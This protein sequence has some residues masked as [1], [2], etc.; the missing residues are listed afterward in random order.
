M[1]ASFSL[2]GPPEL[3]EEL[4]SLTDL[5]DTRV[6]RVQ[7]ASTLIDAVDAPIGP[8]TI[9]AVVS[10]ITIICG[11]TRAIAELIDKILDLIAKHRS[12]PKPAWKGPIG[13]EEVVIIDPISGKELARISLKADKGEL[14]QRLAHLRP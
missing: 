9:T 6:G 1:S 10:A 2:V 4:S 14:L 7:P 12:R 3:I 13:D 5:S 8:E 11:S